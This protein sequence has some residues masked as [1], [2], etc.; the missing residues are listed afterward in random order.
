MA[1][2]RATVDTRDTEPD[3]PEPEEVQWLYSSR[4]TAVAFRVGPWGYSPSGELVGRLEGD[5]V[6]NG[7]YCAE[8]IRGDRLL[9]AFACRGEE[10]E[11]PSPP[12]APLIPAPPAGCRGSIGLPVGYRDVR[13]E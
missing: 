9:R 11:V 10:R 13:Y 12:V 7:T 1:D 2:L 6:W 8:V 4:G 3:A 5:E